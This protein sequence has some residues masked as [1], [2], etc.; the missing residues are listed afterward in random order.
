M[1][2]HQA[3]TEIAQRCG[4]WNE[5]D[6]WEDCCSCWNRSCGFG[7]T[8]DGQL[9]ITEPS[10]K[11]K[12]KNQMSLLATMSLEIGLEKPQIQV[13]IRKHSSCQVYKQKECNLREMK[14][15]IPNQ[16]L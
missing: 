7:F 5:V 14:I 3:V 15:P 6:R 4:I 1:G 9:A 12:K 11:K 8:E 2:E 16:M 13:N 10:A